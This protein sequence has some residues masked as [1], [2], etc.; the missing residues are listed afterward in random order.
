M[1]GNSRY[2]TDSLFKGVKTLLASLPS[3]EEKNELINTLGETKN[4]IEEMQKLVAAFPTIESSRD[5]SEGLSRLD[6]LAAQANNDA[7]LRKVMGLKPPQTSSAKAPI[8]PDDVAL[9]ATRLERIVRN[10]ETDE[11]TKVLE[12]SGEPVTVFM[13]LAR[14]LGLRTRKKERKADLIGRI[15]THIG[16]QREYKIL[17][18]EGPNHA[19][20]A[21]T[22]PRRNPNV[23][24][25]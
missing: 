7:P 11:L 17:R 13:E 16:N 14:S 10:S 5:V 21:V 1:K 23:N 4:F 15:K 2:P 12:G 3:E 24:S 20:L 19:A 18:G 25:A 8:G 6:I 9:R 22:G